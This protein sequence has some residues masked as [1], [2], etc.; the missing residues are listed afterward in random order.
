MSVFEFSCKCLRISVLGSS[1]KTVL[2]F[3]SKCLRVVVLV[4]RVRVLMRVS[5]VQ[6]LRVMSSVLGSS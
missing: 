6:Y 2:E 4:T 1:Y 3:S 5:K